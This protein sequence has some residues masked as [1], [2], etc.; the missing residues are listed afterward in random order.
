MNTLEIVGSQLPQ[1]KTDTLDWLKDPCSTITV[2]RLV[3]TSCEKF[4]FEIIAGGNTKVEHVIIASELED[5]GCDLLWGMKPL[6]KNQNSTVTLLDL[7]GLEVC[8]SFLFLKGITME[9]TGPYMYVKLRPEHRYLAPIG[10]SVREAQHNLLALCTKRRC[11]GPVRRL[12]Y[13]LLNLVKEL[14]LCF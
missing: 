14:L 7:S 9:R 6:F 1:Q 11:R 5:D 13:E 2:I 8:N 10:N 4:P 12:P 3:N